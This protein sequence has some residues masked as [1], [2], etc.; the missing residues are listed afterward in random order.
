MNR[1]TLARWALLL[2]FFVP[3]H[4][5]AAGNHTHYT[6]LEEPR[7]TFPKKF[8]VLPLDVEVLIMSAGGVIE[9]TDSYTQQAR[10][11]FDKSLQTHLSTSKKFQT[12]ALPTLTSAE[13]VEIDDYLAVYDVVASQAFR[14]A[15]FGPAWQHKAK[16][17]DYTL[18]SGLKFIREKTGADAA[19]VFIGRDV[20]SSA[21]RKAAVIFAAVLGVGLPLGFSYMTVG[22]VDLE[23]GDLLWTNQKQGLSDFIDA[24]AALKMVDEVLGDYPGPTV[25]NTVVAANP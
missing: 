7:K 10:S 5:F 17:F 14:L 18:G 20:M 15:G 16:H 3:I 4:A 24:N 2:A 13:R 22:V 21:E 1:Y 9:K 6:L 12:V 25:D 8:V 11:N 23:T 19:V